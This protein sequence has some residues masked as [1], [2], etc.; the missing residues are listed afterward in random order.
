M[1][2]GWLLLA[3]LVLVFG[4][5]FRKFGPPGPRPGDPPPRPSCCARDPRQDVVPPRKRR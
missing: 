2:T 3:G 5:L 4:V 1:L